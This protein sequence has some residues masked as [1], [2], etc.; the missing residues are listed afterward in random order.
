MRWSQSLLLAPVLLWQAWRTRARV[1][2]LPEAS[3][4]RSGLVGQGEP[5]SLLITGDSAAAGVG[6]STQDEALSGQLLRLLAE[7]YTVAWRLEA[8]SGANT[9]A[10]LNHLAGLKR[11]AFDVVVTSLGVNDVTG[12]LRLDRWLAIQKELRNLLRT[13]F[14]PRLVIVSGLPP[15]HGFPALPQP[16]RSYLGD[17]ASA[18]DR[19]LSADLESEA[20]CRFL[21]LRFTEDA[22]Q[23]ASDGFHPGPAVYRQWA[24]RVGEII[25]EAIPPATGVP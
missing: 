23:M 1:P 14:R 13:R 18:F 3:G 17:R 6:A 2:R 11:Q 22:G 12:R 25:M 5:V 10:T 15:V 20:D 21:S 7:H 24:E 19:A 16:L 8:K 4:P 9:R